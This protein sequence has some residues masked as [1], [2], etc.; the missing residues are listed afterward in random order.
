MKKINGR[1]I[2]SVLAAAVMMSVTSVSAG[3]IDYTPKGVRPTY[4]PSQASAVS[5]KDVSDATKDADSNGQK[6]TAIGTKEDANGNV[7]VQEAA[8]AEIA[9]GSVKVTFDIES[10]SGEDYSITIDPALIREVKAINLGMD[11]TVG[12]GKITTAAGVE[13]PKGSVIIEPKQKGDFGM[14]LQ[15]NLH[16]ES[17]KGIDLAKANLFYL[18]NKGEVTKMPGDALKVNAD[19]SASVF[20]S[21]ASKYIISDED[22]T[23]TQDT[24]II[25]E[26]DKDQNNTPVTIDITPA[27][28]DNNPRTGAALAFGAL[29][30]SAA[31]VAVTAKKRK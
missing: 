11:I 4:T 18:D 1:L 9:V 29:A 10:D 30:A 17:F 28:T 20:I 13:V 7:P 12:A 26:T 27:A 15:I 19:G 6:E 24:V 14:T 21:H 2:V 22:L 8:I 3:A 16:A 5:D 31:A 25:S 23:G